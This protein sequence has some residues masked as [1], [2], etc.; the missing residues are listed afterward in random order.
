VSNKDKGGFI[1]IRNT[2]I[3]TDV[4]VSQNNCT[5]RIIV[6]HSGLIYTMTLIL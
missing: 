4:K 5:K 6:V 1:L 3:L 2:V